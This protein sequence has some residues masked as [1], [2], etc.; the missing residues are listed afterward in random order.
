[1]QIYEAQSLVDKWAYGRMMAAGSKD[2][3]KRYGDEVNKT[4]RFKKYTL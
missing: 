4:S 1:M 2:F 3:L